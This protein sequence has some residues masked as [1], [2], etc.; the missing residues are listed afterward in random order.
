MKNFIS[1]TK[2]SVLKE[3]EENNNSDVE[4]NEEKQNNKQEKTLI[5]PDKQEIKIE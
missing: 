4:P 2:R 1:E 3:N 5:L